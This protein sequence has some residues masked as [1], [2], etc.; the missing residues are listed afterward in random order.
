MLIAIEFK[1]PIPPHSPHHASRTVG[2]YS[3][4]KFLNNPQGRHDAYVEVWTAPCNI[5]EEEVEVEG[6]RDQQV[7]LAVATQM[8]LTIPM[9]VNQGLGEKNRAKL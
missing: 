1:S 7:C 6:W 3:S 9:E 4:G 5:E 8:A 2:L